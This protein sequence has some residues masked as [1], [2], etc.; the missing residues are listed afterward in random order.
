MDK[1]EQK[2]YKKL[3]PLKLPKQT[4]NHQTNPQTLKP[5]LLSG[6]SLLNS[7]LNQLDLL[8]SIPATARVAEPTDVS[9]TLDF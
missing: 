5:A 7:N 6:L 1:W 4:I 8:C 3:N 2:T 9:P